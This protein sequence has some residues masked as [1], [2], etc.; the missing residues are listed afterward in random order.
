MTWPGF[1]RCSLGPAQVGRT[2]LLRANKHFERKCCKA[3]FFGPFPSKIGILGF[4]CRGLFDAC[5]WG[6]T[7]EKTP[8]VPQ[9]GTGSNPHIHEV[10]LGFV[11]LPLPGTKGIDCEG[12]EEEGGIRGVCVPQSGMRNLSGFWVF[13]D[14]LWGGL[15]AKTGIISSNGSCDLL[16]WLCLETLNW[17]RGAAQN[18][19]FFLWSSLEIDSPPLNSANLKNSRSFLFFIL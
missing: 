13:Y 6:V 18:L 3:C 12:Q 14:I 2:A 10:L 5:P 9:S 4:S 8:C 16:S 17:L 7:S 1:G 15:P 11:S 19:K